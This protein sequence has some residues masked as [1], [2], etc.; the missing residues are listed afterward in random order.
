[1]AVH[2]HKTRTIQLHPKFL[3]WISY[4][5]TWWAV[6]NLLVSYN[7]L[8][9]NT[10]ISVLKASLIFLTIFIIVKPR[11]WWSIVS[12]VCFISPKS[13]KGCL[14]SCLLPHLCGW[15]V[16]FFFF[17]IN[18]TE[19]KWRIEKGICEEQTS[20]N[21]AAPFSL[22]HTAVKQQFAGV[23]PQCKSS[24]QMKGVPCF[25]AGS[26]F[27]SVK[28]NKASQTARLCCLETKLSFQNTKAVFPIYLLAVFAC[29]SSGN[30]LTPEWEN[31]G[32]WI[33]K[34]LVMWFLKIN[35]N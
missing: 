14:L 21:T 35:K 13:T 2:T 24:S 18:G 12:S 6:H 33:S 19:G 25:L 23:V 29:S 17:Q 8:K 1:M 32:I 9:V 22:V 20:R 15:R 26:L 4:L 28:T 31:L 5:K 34:K 3:F 30:C 7:K 10:Y 16:L 27:L 11:D